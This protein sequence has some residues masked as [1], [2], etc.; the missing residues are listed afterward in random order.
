MKTRLSTWFFSLCS[1]SFCP[2]IRVRMSAAK[3]L[4][5]RATVVAGNRRSLHAGELCFPVGELRLQSVWSEPAILP[6]CKVAV[7]RRQGFH[8]RRRS[9]VKAV[10]KE[11]D[12]ARENAERPLVRDHVVHGQQ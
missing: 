6:H 11:T 1:K 5:R 9:V 3:G 2:A 10:I 7:L 4:R 12:F 8:R